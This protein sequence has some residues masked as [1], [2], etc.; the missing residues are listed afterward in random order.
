MNYKYTTSVIVEKT[1]SVYDIYKESIDDI[2]IPGYKIVAFRPPEEGDRY[3]PMDYD[4]NETK[5][6]SSLVGRFFTKEDPRLIVE[7][8]R[9]IPGAAQ[10]ETDEFFKTWDNT[11]F[12]KYFEP[13]RH[14]SA[15]YGEL[16]F[17]Y[18]Y[19]G[20]NLQIWDKKEYST[21]DKF[22]ILREKNNEK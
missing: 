18:G 13:V 5:R 3:I 20:S 14:G 21:S 6:I 16:F 19:Y 8:V 7:K 17:I 22:F 11:V 4:S 10:E 1:I 2:K 9:E 12:A 15:S